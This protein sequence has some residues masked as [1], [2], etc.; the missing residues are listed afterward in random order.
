VLRVHREEHGYR[1][2]E[3]ARIARVTPAQLADLFLSSSP[4]RRSCG[5]CGPLPA[6]L[7]RRRQM[8]PESVEIAHE[9]PRGELATWAAAP[10]PLQMRTILRVD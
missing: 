9:L 2:S 4:L 1:D 6:R 10:K 7:R 5:P 8:S 3:L